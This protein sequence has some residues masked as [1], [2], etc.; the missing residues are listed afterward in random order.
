MA[1]RKR[2]RTGSEEILADAGVEFESKSI[3]A[4]GTASH[5]IVTGVGVTIDF[6]PGTG[7]WIVRHECV[8][9]CLYGE[10]DGNRHAKGCC[11]RFGK[12]RGRGVRNLLRRIA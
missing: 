10:P 7:L 6:W 9:G 4:D 3:G 8:C 12:E 2:N 11:C 5:L 1:R